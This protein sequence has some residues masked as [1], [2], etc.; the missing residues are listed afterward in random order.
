MNN[1]LLIL[2]LVV[3]LTVGP[4]MIA[5]R[6]LGARSPGFFRSLFAVILLS[7]LSEAI[8]QYAGSPAATLAIAAAGGAM[9]MAL[10]LDTGV[11]RGL[12]IAFVAVLLQGMI[13]NILARNVQ[14][15]RAAIMME[16]PS[17]HV[18]RTAAPQ[19]RLAAASGRA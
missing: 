8:R 2:L 9:I 15:N 11:V 4:V 16:T 13:V 19:P 10:C 18:M 5:G 7:A 14:T 3:A 1:L 12:G 6:L 17:H